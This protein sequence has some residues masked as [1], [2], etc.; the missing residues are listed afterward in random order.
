MKVKTVDAQI[1]PEFL[2]IVAAALE[3]LVNDICPVHK[4]KITKTQIG[5]CVYAVEC[6]C[7]LYVG[8]LEK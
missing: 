3:N 6:G 7:R 8:K 1:K 2:P 4:T 5:K